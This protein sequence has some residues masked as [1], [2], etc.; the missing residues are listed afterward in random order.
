[1]ETFS[2]SCSWFSSGDEL[3]NVLFR[4]VILYFSNHVTQGMFAGPDGE[5]GEKKN[6]SLNIGDKN[7]ADVA[8]SLSFISVYFLGKFP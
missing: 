1:M 3:Q 8:T 5:K 4:R 7:P 2:H 6:I